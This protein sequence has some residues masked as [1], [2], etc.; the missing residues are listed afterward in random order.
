VRKSSVHEGINTLC[1]EDDEFSCGAGSIYYSPDVCKFPTQNL[2]GIQYGKLTVLEFS[3]RNK[4]HFPVWKCRCECGR[5]KYILQQHLLNGRSKTCGD[6]CHRSGIDYCKRQCEDLSGRRVG[7]LTVIRR[8]ENN[9]SNNP[10]WECKCDCGEIIRTTGS[11][12]RNTEIRSCGCLGP[13]PYKHGMSRT[14]EYRRIKSAERKEKSACLDFEWNF[15]MAS[16]ILYFFPRCVICG[17]SSNLSIDHVRALD[18]GY[19]LKPGNATVLCQSC[20]SRKGNRSL[21]EL[22]RETVNILLSSANDFKLYWDM[23]SGLA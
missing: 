21:I 10:V 8:V 6:R 5:E 23:L 16:A 3:G 12:I 2:I 13:A 7:M 22:P 14:T 1:P 20:N 18:L 4:F 17:K 9:S 11:V 19:G 15:D